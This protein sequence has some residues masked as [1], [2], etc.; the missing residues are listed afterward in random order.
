M[1]L[2]QLVSEYI[3]SAK[4]AFD[5][6]D[7]PKSPVNVDVDSVKEV[8]ESAKAYLEDAKYYK[9]KK[10]LDVSLTSIAYCEGLL[11]ALRLLGAVKFEWPTKRKKKREK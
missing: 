9:T 1:S 2:D 11:D 10:E 4:H 5:N 6:M 7:I 3:A 8:L